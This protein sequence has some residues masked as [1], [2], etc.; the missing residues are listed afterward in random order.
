MSL[1]R[2][3]RKF[4]ARA[5]GGWL[6]G[7][8][9]GLV[10]TWAAS[11]VPADR[12]LTPLARLFDDPPGEARPM[13]RWWWFGGAVTPAEITR[14]LTMM[15]DAGLGG[16]EIQPVYPV[17]VDDARRG[18]HHLPYFA[19]EWFCVVRHAVEEA[20]R[21]GLRLDFTLGSGWPYGGP[22]IPT[23]LAARRL[24]VLSRDVEGVRDVAWD[25]AAHVVGDDRIVAVVV[26]PVGAGQSPDLARSRVLPDQ[27]RPEREAGAGPRVEWRAPAGEWRVYVFLDSP[28]G[29]QVKRPTLGMEGPVLDHFS[30]EAM[31]RFLAAAGD[32]VMDGLM[33]AAPFRSVFCDSLEV[34]GADWTKDLIAAFR[35]R[36]GY[37]LGPLLPALWED[38]GERTPHVRHDYHLTL[39]ELFLERFVTP[40]VAWSERRGMTARVQAHGAPGDVMSAYGAAHVPEGESIFGGDRY[41]VNLRH[42]RLASSA[43]HVYGK[44]LASAETYTWL[45]TPLYTTT[46]EMMK[47]AS[48]AMFLDGINHL[49]NHGY[50]YS[51]PEAGEPGWAFYASSEIN[52]TNTWWRHY[53]HLARYVRRVQALLQHGAAVNPVAVYLPLADLYARHGAG[54]LHVDVELERQLGA[55]L[56]AALRAGGYDFD[57]VQDDALAARGRVER[58]RLH[59]GSAV[60]SAVI[61]PP[62]RFMP[63]ASASRLEELA[64]GGGQVLFMGR[65]PESAPGL[66]GQPAATAE[67]QRTLDRLRQAGLSAAAAGGVLEGRGRAALVD[68]PAAVVG[69]LDAVLGPDFEIVGAADGGD[70]ALAAARQ[71]VGFVHRREG[72]AD[73]YFVANVSARPFELR[74]RFAVARR[75]PERW[76]PE[77]GASTP[78]ACEYVTAR[79]RD[80][81]EVG[82]RLGA[83][84]SCFVVFGSSGEAPLVTRATLARL[85]EIRP[86]TGSG[87]LVGEVEGNGEYVVS[88]P[89]GER[90]IRV[91]DLPTPR[92]IE[93][94][95]HLTLG[96]GAAVTLERLVSWAELPAGRSYSGWAAY[97]TEFVFGADASGIEWEIDLGDVHETAEVSLNGEPL[98]AA[99]KAPRRLAC[100]RA[101]HAGRNHL[102]VEVANLWIH[103]MATRPEPAEWKRVDET[104]GIRWGRYGEVKPETL[105]PSGLLGPVRLVPRKR[106]HVKL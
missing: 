60:Y 80:R 70:T 15:R 3:R 81:V 1:S 71:D 8:F 66:A 5:A 77:R 2:S 57:L 18:I 16:A 37:D 25:L 67:L 56:P 19:D 52:H 86:G 43:A 40:L 104:Y 22:F 92:T 23:S 72:A 36:R 13:T 14:E 65:L 9:G 103:E 89:L 106:I 26:A 78:L 100:G 46:L 97:E 99:W 61:V 93:G 54:G 4:I 87:E 59:A 102:R 33:V 68:G 17:A 74:V 7:R 30:A 79:G 51:P 48:D 41:A 75:R 62:V 91:D 53:H 47:A 6:A 69:R 38:A 95:W 83:Y 10:T 64:R 11:P 24:Q 101:L 20:Q 98:G 85:L 96:P 35:E 73:W 88:G 76:D 34:Y 29:Q 28:T 55:E 58:G 45:R 32:R 12:D 50:S 27:P 31:E 94:P 63:A 84:E 49:V 42:R 105:P 44:P 90:R 39:S 82:L 21:L